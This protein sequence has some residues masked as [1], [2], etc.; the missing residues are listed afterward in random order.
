MHEQ[1]TYESFSI[2]SQNL[3]N[4]FYCQAYNWV[5]DYNSVNTKLGRSYLQGLPLT[6]ALHNLHIVWTICCHIQFKVW[7]TVTKWIILSMPWI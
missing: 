4:I 3:L 6:L 2:I 7:A 1:F 5:K